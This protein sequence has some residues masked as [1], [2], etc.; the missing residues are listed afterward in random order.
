[1]NPPAI[2]EGIMHWKFAAGICC[3][4]AAAS[5]AMTATEKDGKKPVAEKRVENMDV[6]MSA[7]VPEL[8][9]AGSTINVKIKIENKSKEDIEFRAMGKYWDYNLKLLDSKGRLVALTK[10]G[11]IAYGGSRDVGSGQMGT[12]GTGKQME[13]T[14]NLS[15]IFDLSVGG[16]YKLNL[17]RNLNAIILK[18][19]GLRFKLGEELD[20]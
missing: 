18:I 17:S 19:D 13:V 16:E 15:R 14:L 11:K 10:F 5:L 1:M 12:L 20:R 4:V 2:M 9:V 7:S 8:S 3:L 6:L